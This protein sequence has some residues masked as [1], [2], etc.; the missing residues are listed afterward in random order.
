M[1][2]SIV[3]ISDNE[4]IEA[5]PCKKC[6]WHIQGIDKNRCVKI[7][8]K[9]DAY[10]D[11][12]EY[13]H[14]PCLK[15]EELQEAE[16]E[17]CEICEICKLEGRKGLAKVRGLCIR[18]YERWRHGLVVHPVLGKFAYIQPQ[19]SQKQEVKSTATCQKK[20]KMGDN[21]PKV[22][23]TSA[24]GNKDDIDSIVDDIAEKFDEKH[25][26]KAEDWE[27][28]VCVIC[29]DKSKH[30]LNKR[31]QTC[32]TCYQAWNVGKIEHPTLGKFK[33]S[34]TKSIIK[35][36]ISH[37][38]WQQPMPK[39]AETHPAPVKLYLTRYPKL[40]TFILDLAEKQGLPPAHVV[41]TLIAE[42]VV[43]REK[44]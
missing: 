31:S 25:A 21:M 42:A 19:K 15:L 10:R 2:R 12:K 26:L 24:K 6:H 8:Q 1:T 9:L 17:I 27:K 36:N 38:A 14:L 3:H 43:A 7:C 16:V 4:C 30:I 40:K 32:A 37:E 11:G 18:D 20:K 13:N 35:K 33:A 29:L 22:K 34:L 5:S 39:N 23:K 44:K 28:E 41:L